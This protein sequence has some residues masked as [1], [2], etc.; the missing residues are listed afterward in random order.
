MS[1]CVCVCVCVCLC[2][3]ERKSERVCVC[4]CVCVCV[5]ETACV[6]EHKVILMLVLGRHEC[7]RGKWYINI[8]KQVFSKSVSQG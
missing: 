1:E 7:I 8:N 5:E 4:V 3:C 2:V 6:R